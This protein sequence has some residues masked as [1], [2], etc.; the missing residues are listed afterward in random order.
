MTMTTTPFPFQKRRTGQELIWG[1]LRQEE[2]LVDLLPEL[3]GLGRLDEGQPQIPAQLHGDGQRRPVC[4]LQLEHQKG[5]P[6]HPFPC[7]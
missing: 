3:Q 4:P 7:P 2:G 1:L 5:P 6:P